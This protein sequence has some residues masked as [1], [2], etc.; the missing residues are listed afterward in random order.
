MRVEWNRTDAYRDA[1][2]NRTGSPAM[3]FKCCRC[4]LGRAIVGRKKVGQDGRR[5]QWAC[6]TCAEKE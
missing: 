3:T 5:I 1:T 2:K 6:A 4:G